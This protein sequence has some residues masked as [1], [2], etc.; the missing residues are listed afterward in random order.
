MKLPQMMCDAVLVL[1]QRITPEH[2]PK[3]SSNSKSTSQLRL[4]EAEQQVFRWLVGRS[5]VCLLL[6]ALL[7]LRWA[8]QYV[9]LLGALSEAFSCKAFCL[10][11][12]GF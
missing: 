7:L 1:A 11:A 12:S 4:P 2:S 9:L 5:V 3:N 6:A 8:F 10:E